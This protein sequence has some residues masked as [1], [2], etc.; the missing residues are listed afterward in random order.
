MMLLH[1]AINR[2]QTESG[3]FAGLLDGKERFKNSGKNLRG[4]AGA[5][6]GDTQAH[7]PAGA[8]LRVALDFSLGDFPCRS[9]DRQLSAPG[10]GITRVH[11]EVQ[12]DLFHHAEITVHRRQI[13]RRVERQSNGGAQE[14]SQ[15]LGCALDHVVQIQVLG[16][17]RLFPA[18][19][20]QLTGQIGG[21]FGGG[22]HL[23]QR[24]FRILAFH[25]SAEN[26]VGM[27]LDDRQDVV[28]VMRHACGELA[29]R[30]HLLQLAQL[31]LELSALGNVHEDSD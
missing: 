25:H 6:I 3:A 7:K 27:P 8:R 5:G 20:Q 1:Y 30:F 10:H 26:H 24:F 18:E 17:H 11:S 9:A 31:L 16:L 23:Y 28:K 21:A 2:G 29:D 13:R 15:H 22:A 4:D 19:R 14:T 12:K